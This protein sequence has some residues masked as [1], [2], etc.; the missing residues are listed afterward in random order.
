MRDAGFKASIGAAERKLLLF[1]GMCLLL[2]GMALLAKSQ[3][4]SFSPF[5]IMIGLFGV[6]V[7]IVKQTRSES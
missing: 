1:L 5:L 2:T 3:G 7:G 6:C 4:G